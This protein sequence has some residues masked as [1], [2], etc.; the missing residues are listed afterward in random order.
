MSVLQPHDLR[1]SS[2]QGLC[3]TDIIQ[4]SVVRCRHGHCSFR[5]KVLCPFPW[6]N[7]GFCKAC[8]GSFYSHDTCKSHLCLSALAK[9]HSNHQECTHTHAQTP[10]LSFSLSPG[11][12]LPNILNPGPI[13]HVGIGR[14]HPP[15]SSNPSRVRWCQLNTCTHVLLYQ[16][17]VPEI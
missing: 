9:N 11:N 2:S 13:K 1:Q 5:F 6:K 12:F 3:I 7:P 15:N 14:S 10:S 4:W 16:E 8:L 17:F